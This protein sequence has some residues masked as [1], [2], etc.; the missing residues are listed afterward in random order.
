M[1]VIDKRLLPA[2]LYIKRLDGFGTAPHFPVRLAVRAE[3]RQLRV[4][5]LVA[6]S[7]VKAVLPMGCLN[8]GHA[9]GTVEGVN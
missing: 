6:P 9:E 1:F 3:P 7:G 2:V 8:Q 4:R 5:S